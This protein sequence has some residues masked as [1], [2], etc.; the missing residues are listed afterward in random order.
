MPIFPIIWWLDLYTFSNLTKNE[1]AALTKLKQYDD[2][3][4]KKADKGGNASGTRQ[5][6]LS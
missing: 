4:I 6:F 1:N 2:I 3:I 5:S